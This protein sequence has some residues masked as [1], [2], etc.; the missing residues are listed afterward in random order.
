VHIRRVA[1]A[2]CAGAL[3]IASCDRL[4]VVPASAPVPARASVPAPARALDDAAARS[5]RLFGTYLDAHGMST[6]AYSDRL[7]EFS[8]IEAWSSW[9]E[10]EHCHACWDWT[11]L[12]RKLATIAKAGASAKSTAFVWGHDAPPGKPGNLTPGYL[13]QLSTPALRAELK[14]H[15]QTI[16]R[17]YPQVKVWTIANEPFTNPD[18]QGH[19]GM[20]PNVFQR[21]LGPGWIREALIDAYAA[22]PKATFIAVNEINADAANAKSDLMYLYYLRTLVGAIPKSHLAVGLQMH[23][24][25]CPGVH[26]DPNVWQ[27]AQNMQRFDR[28]GVRVHIT[29]MDYGIRCIPG[30]FAQELGAQRAK[31]YAVARFCMVM[32]NCTAMSVWGVG[33]A[34]SW[35]RWKRHD[36]DWPLLFDDHYRPKPAYYGVLDALNGR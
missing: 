28:L 20:Y 4:P 2:C 35:L 3:T 1:L 7:E 23:L 29:E 27:V 21:R 26:L 15:I 36:Y 30:S 13:L 22:N 6:P 33:D 24:D 32:R 16:V 9:T 25:S 17:R 5:G 11:G 31:Y 14:H 18:G 10:L 34:D 19:V 12:D 8:L